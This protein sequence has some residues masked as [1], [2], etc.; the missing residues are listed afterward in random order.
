MK[1][2]KW[3]KMV[4]KVNFMLCVFYHIKNLV[5]E[6]A[7]EKIILPLRIPDDFWNEV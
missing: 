7:E 4:K 6:K 2:L 1:W 3:L 5:G